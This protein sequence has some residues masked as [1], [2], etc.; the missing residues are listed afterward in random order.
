MFNVLFPQLIANIIF[1]NA[2]TVWNESAVFAIPILPHI[3]D[4]VKP[5]VGYTALAVLGNVVCLSI[6]EVL[7]IGII[8]RQLPSDIDKSDNGVATVPIFVL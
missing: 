7:L 8:K 4:V 3:P 2:S 1:P 5:E 6:K